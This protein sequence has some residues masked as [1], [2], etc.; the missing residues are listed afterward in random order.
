MVTKSSVSKIGQSTFQDL[1]TQLFKGRR[2]ETSQI[3]AT[4][5]GVE[6]TPNS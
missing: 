3:P 2:V 6:F 5:A 4:K 1:I